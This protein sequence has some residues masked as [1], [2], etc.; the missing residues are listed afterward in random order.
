MGKM[1]THEQ[2]QR[3]IRR[4]P[5]TVRLAEAVGRIAA[6]CKEQRP[7]KMSI[8]ASAKDDDIFIITTLEDALAEIDALRQWIREE[9]ERT[10]ICT[11]KILGEICDGCRCGAADGLIKP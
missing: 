6:M 8:P 11:Q 7:P 2:L 4:Q 1:A 9:G 10:D 3:S 5:L